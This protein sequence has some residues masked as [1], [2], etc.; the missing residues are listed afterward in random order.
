M[1]IETLSN[2]RHILYRSLTGDFGNT[3]K[4][5]YL[6]SKTNDMILKNSSK[7]IMIDENLMKTKLFVTKIIL[8]TFGDINVNKNHF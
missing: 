4:L 1:I 5:R 7:L 3:L 8:V 6:R 2:F